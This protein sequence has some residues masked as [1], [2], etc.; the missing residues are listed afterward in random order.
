MGGLYDAATLRA[1]V[2]MREWRSAICRRDETKS[3]ECLAATAVCLGLGRVLCT[4]MEKAQGRLDLF[5]VHMPHVPGI[6][7]M[8]LTS[9]AGDQPRQAL[10]VRTPGVEPGPQ[11]WGGLYDAAT[12]RALVAMRDS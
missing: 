9:R 4:D 10:S 1:L 6:C 11:A 2:A 3:E 5:V 7:R 8:L 12:L